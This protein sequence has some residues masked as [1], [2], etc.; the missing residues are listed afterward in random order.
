M[1]PGDEVEWTLASGEIDRGV[2]DRIERGRVYVRNKRAGSH[3]RSRNKIYDCEFWWEAHEVGALRLV[4]TA[5]NKIEPGAC[6]RCRQHFLGDHLC[7]AD[8]EEHC[9]IRT[10]RDGWDAACSCSRGRP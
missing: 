10:S 4:R 6:L 2:V 5:T 8:H 3:G 1:S 7:A 9:D